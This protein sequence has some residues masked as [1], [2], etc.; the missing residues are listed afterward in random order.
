MAFGGGFKSSDEL[1]MNFANVEFPEDLRNAQRNGTL[2]IFV[3]AGV[4]YPPPSS[5]PDFAK[6]ADII[7]EGVSSKSLSEREDQYL[8]RLQVGGLNIHKIAR[9]KLT[10]P[11]S[12]PTELHTLVFRLFKDA[13]TTRLVTTN[14]DRHLTTAI[15]EKLRS[16]LEI[17]Y[18]P[19]L[20]LGRD[21]N[22]LVYL[23]GSV[24]RDPN[25]MVLT[26][27][28][29]GRAYLTDGWATRF[30]MSLFQD[31][32]VLFVGYSHSDVVMNYLARGLPP[33]AQPRFALTSEA[34]FSRWK[35]LGIEALHYQPDNDH[36]QL[37]EAFR[38]WVAAAEMGA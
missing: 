4:S 34:D 18:A 19:A 11:D 9:D 36:I 10:I 22:G 1:T 14:F 30:L 29:F 13:S 23:H 32:I 24:D 3:G 5:L 38:D 20:P 2:V 21:F 6:L 28:D 8:G 35:L 33:N 7:G 12:K 15:P 26:D 31:H 27:A 25:L 37:T 16:A 17:F